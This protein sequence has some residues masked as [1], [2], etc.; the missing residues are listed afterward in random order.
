MSV[1]PSRDW[2]YAC[3]HVNSDGIVS[4]RKDEIHIADVMYAKASL[5][6]LVLV[7]C[8]PKAFVLERHHARTIHEIG[9]LNGYEK[10]ENKH[11]TMNVWIVTISFGLPH[12]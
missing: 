12:A 3:L 7:Y 5:A 1:K 10:E 8:C 9:Y 2:S 6:Y 11:I 4:I